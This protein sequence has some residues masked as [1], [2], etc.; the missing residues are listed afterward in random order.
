MNYIPRHK[1]HAKPVD[2]DGIKFHS[3]KE[4]RYYQQ[5][6]ILKRNGDVVFF[7]RQTP[8]HLPG[9]V[10]Y[11]ADF[12]VFWSDG[13]AEVV[14]VKGYRTPQYKEKK[15]LVEALYPIKIVEI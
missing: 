3:K 5:L 4:G 7:L 9:G 15:K 11:R 10:V 13:R 2:I 6:K 8:F 14:D 1:Y 12:M